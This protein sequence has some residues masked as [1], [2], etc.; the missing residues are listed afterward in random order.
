MTAATFFTGFAGIIAILSLAVY[1]FG[2]PPE[3]KRKLERSALKTMGENKLSYVAKGAFSPHLALHTYV[4]PSSQCPTFYS[5][6]F[7]LLTPTRP[8][9]QAPR[10]RPTRCPSSQEGHQH[11][12]RRRNPK[13]SRRGNRRGRRQLDQSVHRSLR[14]LVRS[15]SREPSLGY[16]T[17]RY[18]LRARYG[19]RVFE[20]GV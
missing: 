2:I 5:S 18:K 14:C 17:D 7:S 6:N 9:Q 20:W 15:A 16:C 8:D 3:L 4:D 13:S 11:P 10:L 12:R 19:A 1:F